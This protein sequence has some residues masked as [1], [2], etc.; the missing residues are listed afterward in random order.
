MNR[1]TLLA[2]LAAALAAALAF[3]LVG[4]EAQVRHPVRRRARRVVR[5]RYRR[6]VVVR[7]VNGRPLWVVPVALAVGWELV[8]RDRVVIVRETRVIEREGKRVEVA[9]VQDSA[10]KTEEIEI[11]REDTAENR[12]ELKGS[13]LPEGDK[14]T[15][16]IEEAIET[17]K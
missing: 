3:G 1:R 7:I 12:A 2:S 4:A 14:T 16:G 11:F 17:D 6:R 5:Y 10:G 15:P 9:L 13:A 8:H